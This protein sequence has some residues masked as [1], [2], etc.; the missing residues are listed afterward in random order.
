MIVNIRGTSGSGKTTLMRRLMG[1]YPIR[2]K[3][4]V[5][6]RRQPL[7]YML[8]KEG[9]RP[10]AVIGHYETACG[11]C[12]TITNMDEIFKLVR[13][14]DTS[15]SDVLYEGLLI[16]ADIQRTLALHQEGR[17]MLVVALDTPLDVCIASINERRRTKTPDKPDVATKNTE[18][19]FKGVRSSMKRLEEAGVP[20]LW[21][22]RDDA[23]NRITKELG[24]AA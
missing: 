24:H 18:S 7:G 21:A 1:L 4:F 10:L 2:S 22:S 8:Y 23:F 9:F 12:D 5:E 13:T 6:G 17:R 19:K 15:A 14:C 20:T 11:G 3:Y 16:S